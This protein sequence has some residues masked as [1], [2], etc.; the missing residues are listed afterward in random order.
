M[1]IGGGRLDWGNWDF[2]KFILNLS[3]G[4]FSVPIPCLREAIPESRLEG[5]AV[6]GAGEERREE[7]E[8]DSLEGVAGPQLR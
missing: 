5:V 7:E 4:L 8:G 1:G 3:L 2:E 6:S